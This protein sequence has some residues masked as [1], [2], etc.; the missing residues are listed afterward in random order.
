MDKILDKA[1]REIQIGSFVKIRSNDYEDCIVVGF[2]N[3]NID[4]VEL[5]EGFTADP[6]EI[7]VVGE[8]NG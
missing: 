1:G 7:E 2:D 3:G 8:L 6:N 4:V 5:R